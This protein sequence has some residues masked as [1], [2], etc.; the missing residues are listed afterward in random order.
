MKVGADRFGFSAPTYTRHN[1]T[2]NYWG[3][4]LLFA[5]VKRGLIFDFDLLDEVILWQV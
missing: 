5:P 4:F 3:G 1:A 2:F